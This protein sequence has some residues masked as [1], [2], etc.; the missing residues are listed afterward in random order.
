MS[1]PNSRVPV[2]PVPNLG[3]VPSFEALRD[4]SEERD[5]LRRN[6][7]IPM[8]IGLRQELAAREL[9]VV[10]E[11][12]LRKTG[13]M[14]GLL[15]DVNRDGPSA[16]AAIPSETDNDRNRKWLL[17]LAAFFCVAVAAALVRTWTRKHSD[18]RSAPAFT[19]AES[20]GSVMAPSISS[21]IP[22]IHVEPPDNTSAAGPAETSPTRALT[23]PPRTVDSPQ[24][25]VKPKVRNTASGK[26]ERSTDVDNGREPGDVSFKPE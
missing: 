12:H 7:T 2:S 17:V 4:D 25:I 11:E 1:K 13:D 19:T 21:G 10:P 18:L 16:A 6:Q 14:D 8:P 20:P 24:P 23:K 22:A 9:P 5:D 26:P 3:R 15:A